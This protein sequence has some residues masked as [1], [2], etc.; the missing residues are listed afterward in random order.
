MVP[1]CLVSRCQ[2]SRFQSSRAE[3]LSWAILCTMQ[4]DEEFC[5]PEPNVHLVAYNCWTIFNR[6][7]SRFMIVSVLRAL[8]CW[9][10]TLL[11]QS[12][13]LHSASSFFRI[14]TMFV[15][16]VPWQMYHLD[17]TVWNWT[18][19][20]LP[21]FS[22]PIVPIA[23]SFP[24]SNP[25]RESGGALWAPPAWKLNSSTKNRRQNWHGRN[26]A[27]DRTFLG[28]WFTIDTLS[29]FFSTSVLLSIFLRFTMCIFAVNCHCRFYVSYGFFISS[30]GKVVRQNTSRWII[31]MVIIQ[32]PFGVNLS[33]W[34]ITINVII[35]T[36]DNA[37]R[38]TFWEGVINQWDL[39]AAAVV[40]DKRKPMWLTTHVRFARHWCTKRN[41]CTKRT[42]NDQKH[43]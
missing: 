8:I 34:R 33:M 29:D 23:I 32:W 7:F 5:V 38:I 41:N 15:P 12:I 20:F 4:S 39:T 16:Q 6:T 25:A 11:S 13:S 22:S 42:E 2:V 9:E 19:P 27:A 40:S 18:F 35:N 37:V 21:S 30:C 28:A 36:W 10:S 31:V 3:Q 17:A 1:R 14:P 43:F 24:P 26:S